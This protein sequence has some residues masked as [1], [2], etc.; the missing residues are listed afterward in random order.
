[1]NHLGPVFRAT[2]ARD[3]LYADLYVTYLESHTALVARLRDRSVSVEEFERQ[4]RAL[5]EE[6]V[7]LKRLRSDL[8]VGKL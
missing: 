2:P 3:S 7:Y 6:L 4:V 1:M 5:G 8:D